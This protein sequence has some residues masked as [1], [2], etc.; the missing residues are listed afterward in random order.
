MDLSGSAIVTGAASGIGK[1]IALRFADFKCFQLFLVDVDTRGLEITKS[2]IQQKISSAKVV[3]KTVDLTQNRAGEDIVESA[4]SEFGRIDYLVNCAGTPGGFFTAVDTSPEI[5][6]KVQNL[7]VRGTWLLQR[8]VLQQM[9]KQ[10]CVDNERGSVVNIGSMVSHVAQPRLSAYITSK[11]AVLGITKADAI[12]FAARG[13]R[14]NCV[15]PG[16]IETNLGRAIPQEIRDQN[17]TPIIEKTPMGRPGR[18]DEVAD[19]V[20]FLASKLAS[21]VTGTSVAVDGGYTAA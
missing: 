12:D 14:I 11:H 19:V 17:L 21:Y 2:Q 9:L 18:P 20:V 10:E 16:Y 4:V 8:A 15:A 5:F 13:I 7:N 3:T 1:A 6:D